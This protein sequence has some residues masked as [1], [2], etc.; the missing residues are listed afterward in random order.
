[1]SNS[2]NRNQKRAVSFE[3]YEDEND[4][5][6]LYS[7][8]NWICQSLQ[9]T[10]PVEKQR[11]RTTYSGQTTSSE[12]SSDHS[13]HSDK[14][15]EQKPIRGNLTPNTPTISQKSQERDHLNHSLQNTQLYPPISFSTASKIVAPNVAKL[16]QS[17]IVEINLKSNAEDVIVVCSVD[18]LK[19]KSLYFQSLL[20]EQEKTTFPPNSV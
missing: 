13:N 7:P 5:N 6:F 11:N 4:S 2:Q 14:D 12:G 19:M 17:S 1:M 8:T 15:Q 9:Y 20:L 18:I 16:S 3:E 10:S